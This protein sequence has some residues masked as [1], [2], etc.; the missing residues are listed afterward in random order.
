MLTID[1]IINETLWMVKYIGGRQEL[2]KRSEIDHKNFDDSV[3]IIDISCKQE[4]PELQK[5]AD[6]YLNQHEIFFI[7]EYAEKWLK[8]NSSASNK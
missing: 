8:E 3:L 1:K 4:D 2:M 6:D 5:F 7:R